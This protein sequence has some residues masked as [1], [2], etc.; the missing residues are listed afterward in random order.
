MGCFLRLNVGLYTVGSP[1]LFIGNLQWDF[2]GNINWA[3]TGSPLGLEQTVS[4][5]IVSGVRLFPPVGTFLQITAPI[6]PGSS[7]SPV[8]NMKGEVVG[9]VSFHISKGQNLNFAIPAQYISDLEELKTLKTVFEWNRQKTSRL[10]VYTE[11]KGAR[12][13][14]LNIKRRFHQGIV[15]EPGSYHIEVSSEGFKTE[16]VWIKIRRGEDRNLKISLEKRP[17]LYPKNLDELLMKS[18][19]YVEKKEYKR[20]IKLLQQVILKNPAY[21]DAYAYLGI[22]Y[23]ILGRNPEAIEVCKHALRIKPDLAMAHIALGAAFA[24][25]GRYT[26]AIEAYKNAIRINPG[27]AMAHF[28]LGAVYLHSG[29]KSLALDEYKILKD[30]DKKLADELF[31]LIYE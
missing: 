5:G 28:G 24:N 7:G 3:E 13:R 25:L 2:T 23:G 4:E 19:S 14:I 12:I 18:S 8:L 30:L 31:D 20:A 27:H 22:V 11:P 21:A 9:I 10:S 6:S 16:K 26:E 17:K 15:V 29:K 1:T